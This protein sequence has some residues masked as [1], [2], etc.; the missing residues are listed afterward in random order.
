MSTKPGVKAK[1]PDRQERHSGKGYTAG[2]RKGGHGG[3][4]KAGEQDGAPIALDENDPNY[5]SDE[6]EQQQQ[7]PAVEEEKKD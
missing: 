3:W 7:E 2:P 4:G 1:N 6:E 5:Q